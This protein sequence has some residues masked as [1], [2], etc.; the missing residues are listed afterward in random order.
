M[1]KNFTDAFASPEFIPILLLVVGAMIGYFRQQHTQSKVPG[2]LSVPKDLLKST[3]FNK[4]WTL[5]YVF[6]LP[7]AYVLNVFSCYVIKAKVCISYNVIIL[8][9]CVF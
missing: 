6:L 1:L 7:L 9:V 3:E 4:L 8:R 5:L 2:L